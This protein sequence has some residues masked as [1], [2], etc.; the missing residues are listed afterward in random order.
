[1][2][3]FQN[4][5][6]TVGEAC[7]LSVVLYWSGLEVVSPSC[8]PATPSSV[9]HGVS[10]A[11]GWPAEISW[12]LQPPPVGAVKLELLGAAIKI[13]G[14]DVLARDHAI[15]ENHIYSAQII[16]TSAAGGGG[17]SLNLTV[18]TVLSKP[19]S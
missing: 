6:F 16:P 4:A 11:F 18:M 5:T 3:G 8:S 12:R 19:R 10:A 17:H 9:G 15:R 13:I 2:I 14:G 1:L 7:A